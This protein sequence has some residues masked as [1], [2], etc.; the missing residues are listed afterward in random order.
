[1]L[2]WCLDTYMIR[3]ENL[4]LTLEE[5]ILLV[6]DGERGTKRRRVQSITLPAGR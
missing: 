1:M 5:P 6:G 3:F 2:L 4:S